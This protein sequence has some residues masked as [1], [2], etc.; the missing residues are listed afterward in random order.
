MQERRWENP[1]ISSTDEVGELFELLFLLTKFYMKTK[2]EIE[3]IYVHTHSQR[4]QKLR[5]FVTHSIPWIDEKMW[6]ESHVIL[7][8]WCSTL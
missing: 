7:P 2:S 6:C 3:N 8:I 4:V 5:Q 1:C